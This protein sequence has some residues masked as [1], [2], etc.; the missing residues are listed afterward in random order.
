MILFV[1]IEQLGNLW[2]DVGISK[3]YQRGKNIYTDIQKL[4]YFE[5]KYLFFT[6]TI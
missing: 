3:G 6:M 1:V 2:T 5:L 4:D